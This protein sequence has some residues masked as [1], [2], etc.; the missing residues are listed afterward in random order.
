MAL[1]CVVGMVDRRRGGWLG[2]GVGAAL[3]LCALVW[4]CPGL[5][6]GGQA[7]DTPAAREEAAASSR[8]LLR[9][10]QL[11][12]ALLPPALLRPLLRSYLMPV[13]P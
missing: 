10:A 11:C 4:V 1:K 8:A 2:D 12:P 5:G 3:F 13:R 7:W 9:P 6:L